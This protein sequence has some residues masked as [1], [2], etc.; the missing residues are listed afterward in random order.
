[1][2]YTISDYKT[3]DETLRVNDLRQALYD[4][5]AILMEKVLV[6]LHGN[7][8]K[9]RR[10]VEARILRPNYF[11]WY[12]AEVYPKTLQ[13]TIRPYLEAGQADLVDLAYR[14]LL[15]LTADFSGVDRPEK[16]PEETARLLGMLRTFGKAAT[17]GQ[18]KGDREAIVR[19]IEA[20]LEE[21]D[22]DFYQPSKQR[23]LQE[24]ARLEAGEITEDELPRDI[25]T[26]LI[27]NQDSL[28]LS[29]EVLMK[30]TAFFLLAGAFTSIHTLTHSMHELFERLQDAAENQ[31][32]REDPIYLQRCIHESMRLHPS[33]P[34]AMRRPTCPF[35]TR[36]GDEL[37]E[38]DTL[39]I[40]LM[41]ANRDETVFG[42][43]AREHNPER[44]LPKGVQPYGLSFGRGM[45]ACIGINLAAG[46]LPK[47]DTDPNTHQYG[48]IALTA[49]QLLDYNAQPDPEHPGVVDTST[50]RNNWASYPLLF[51]S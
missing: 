36:E 8:H 2:P 34:T 7:E 17:L 43:D 29:D 9:M 44:E 47:E 48:I 32:V 13:E 5:G 10:T 24:I 42:S 11:R 37:N 49:R 46:A 50:I 39:V 18:A 40:D 35:H 12:E 27:R 30:E 20:A 26:E 45:H 22:R 25:L 19:E 4:A 33:S 15:N 1:M 16:S 38:E 28:E 31:R 6:N 51:R 23:R 41:S 14:I 3:A 21:F